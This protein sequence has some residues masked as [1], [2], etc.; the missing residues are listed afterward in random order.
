MSI[1]NVIDSIKLPNTCYSSLGE[2]CIFLASLMSD[3]AIG[4]DLINK[5]NTSDLCHFQREVLTASMSSTVMSPPYATRSAM[6][7]TDAAGTEKVTLWQSPPTC[8]GHVVGG[9][10]EP[11]SCKTIEMGSFVTS[12]QPSPFL[13]YLIKSHTLE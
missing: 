12:A 2:N 10:N 1:C 6:F 7:P 3:L 8:S 11:L 13:T 9:R 5:I 4:T